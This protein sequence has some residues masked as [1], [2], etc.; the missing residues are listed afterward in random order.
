MEKIHVQDAI[1]TALAGVHDLMEE[2][3]DDGP[4][5]RRLLRVADLLIKAKGELWIGG[6]L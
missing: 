6:E 5:R 3:R 1:R 4:R 2:A